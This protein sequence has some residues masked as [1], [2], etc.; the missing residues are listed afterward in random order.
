MKYLYVFFVLIFTSSLFGTDVL[1]ESNISKVDTMSIL[2][3][4]SFSK[5]LWTIFFFILTYIAISLFSKIL[6]YF[7]EKSSQLRITLKSFIPI[8]R[9]F[10]WIIFIFIIIKE[11]YHPPKEMIIGA[12]ASVAI[13]V[14]FAT[15]D[16][17]KNIFGGLMLFFEH[18][19][20]VGDKIKVA[21]YYGEVIN[22]GLRAT[23]IVT[24]DDSI[25]HIP[26]MEIMNSSLSNS[27]T[28]ELNC[29][30]IAKIMLPVDIPIDKVRNIA[31]KSAQVSKYVYLNKPIIILFS[32]RMSDQK[33]YLEMKIKAY[34]MDIR[35]EFQFQSDLTETVINELQKQSILEKNDF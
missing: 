10:L 32:N 14:G 4:L 1:Q 29:Q 33:P 31:I 35:Y 34:V 26:N 20:K 18:P 24:P 21:D 15:Q 3:I 13:A 30:V 19:F 11:I 17:L 2:N 6:I 23:Q 9:I 27:N 8:I 25:V 16:L 28:G 5:I 22:I 7:S 12:L